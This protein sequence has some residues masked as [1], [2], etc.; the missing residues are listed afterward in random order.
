MNKARV[1]S[2]FGGLLSIAAFC[3]AGADVP[4]APATPAAPAAPATAEAQAAPEAQIPFASKGGIWTWRVVDDKTVLIESRARK[5]YKA[6]LFGNCID[7]SFA[8][9]LAFI[10]N[11]SG[12]FDK[13]STIRTRGQRCPL[14]SLVE[15]AAPPKKAKK[16]AAP[17]PAHATTLTS[18]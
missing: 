10:P 12:T 14:V 16:A 8:N 15:T 13:F 4:A 7:L 11:P 3:A 5:W 9:E 6:T 17:T 1:L 18:P 2:V